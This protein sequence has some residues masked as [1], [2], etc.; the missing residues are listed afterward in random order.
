MGGHGAVI[1]AGWL[2]CVRA[3]FTLAV[4]VG[5]CLAPASA[6]AATAGATPVNLVEP[7]AGT[8]F[9]HLDLAPMVQFDPGKDADGRVLKPRWVLLA[10]DPEMRST[11]RYCRQFV[12]ASSGGAFHWGCNRWATGVSQLG[13]DQLFAL[14]PGTVYYWQVVSKS[15]VADA[16]DVTSDVRSF[17][18]DAAPSGSSIAEIS[19]QV[20]SNALGEGDG[21]NVGAASFTRSGVRIS[22]MR[23]SRI[24]TFAFRINVTHEGAIDPSRS[25]VKIKSAAGTRFV[26]VAA[27]GSGAVRGV[28]RLTAAERRL[29]TKRFVYQT[30]LRSQR[31]GAMVRSPQRV[32]LIRST[33]PVP[34]WQPD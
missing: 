18:I 14:E 6:T 27:S 5:A 17:A 13:I 22:N 9:D 4:F 19:N 11:V 7:A 33:A 24:S 34:T 15:N 2:R 12:W 32:L 21:L 29:R 25:W 3:V 23:S 20:Y 31:N 26:S 30:F 10:T 8:H 16:P 1:D 28:F